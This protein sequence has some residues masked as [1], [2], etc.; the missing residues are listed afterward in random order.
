MPVDVCEEEISEGDPTDG[1]G[2]TICMLALVRFT[3]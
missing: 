1:K 2:N 3:T